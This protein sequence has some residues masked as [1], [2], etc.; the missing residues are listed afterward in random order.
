MLQAKQEREAKKAK[1]A[2]PP[3]KPVIRREREWMDYVG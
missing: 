1:A 3:A 2:K